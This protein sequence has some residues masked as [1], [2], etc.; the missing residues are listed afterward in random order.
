MWF[1][2]LMN[3]LLFIY[4]AQ[5]RSLSYFGHDKSTLKETDNSLLR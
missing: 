5:S 2:M 3:L 4:G 1:V